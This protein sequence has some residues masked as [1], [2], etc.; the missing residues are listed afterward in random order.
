VDQ[1]PAQITIYR[2]DDSRLDRYATYEIIIDNVTAGGIVAGG[3]ET[4]SVATGRHRV[5]MRYAWLGS[6]T[7][8][9]TAVSGQ[10][11]E[12]LCSGSLWPAKLVNGIL[13]W[14]HYLILRQL[15]P[16]DH[17]LLSTKRARP[18]RVAREVVP[19]LLGT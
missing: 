18:P 14:N 4:F 19:G 3:K 5:R 10:E 8:F 1:T 13:R 11:V 17:K 6:N 9:V 16:G 2:Q 7:M 15:A 12:L